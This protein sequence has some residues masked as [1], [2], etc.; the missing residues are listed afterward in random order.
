MTPTGSPK[1]KRHKSAKKKLV[2]GAR[3]L[4]RNPE[5][6]VP[7]AIAMLNEVAG[8]PKRKPKTKKAALTMARLLAE[9]P[10]VGHG[11]ID[12]LLYIEREKG[13]SFSLLCRIFASPLAF[14]T[15]KGKLR[16]I[17]KHRGE[18]KELFEAFEGLR[19]DVQ[20]AYNRRIPPSETREV[21]EC[22]KGEF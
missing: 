13:I 21:L 16:A 12:K 8:H 17:S 14:T 18:F 2:I 10:K 6:L 4:K 11:A 3:M 5:K 15:L 7:E 20:W 9:N 1:H 22:P 19:K